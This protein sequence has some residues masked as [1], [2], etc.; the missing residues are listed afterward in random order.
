M[1]SIQVI[2]Q[3]WKNFIDKPEVVEQKAKERAKI[4]GACPKAKHGML[5]AF[6]KDNLEEIEGY[7]CDECKCPLSAK[8]RSNDKCPLG[9][10]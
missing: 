2:M 5:L 3:G 6:I 7:Y 9:K 10:W 4:C 8:V 1:A